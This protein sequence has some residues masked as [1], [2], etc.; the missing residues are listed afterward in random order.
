[1]NSTTTPLAAE[2]VKAVISAV[3]EG[4]KNGVLLMWSWLI[5]LLKE[6]WLLTGSGLL[7]ILIFTYVKAITTGRWGDFGSVLYKSIFLGT[8]F[9]IGLIFG[10]QVFVSDY[11]EIVGTI[12]GGIA[13]VAAG[14]VLL[15]LG[16]KART[17]R[18]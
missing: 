7:V 13:F 11:F 16:F 17:R 4:T 18:W 14:W 8:L 2:F 9:I 6:H 15:M 5:S 12:I 3:E 10:P 1:M